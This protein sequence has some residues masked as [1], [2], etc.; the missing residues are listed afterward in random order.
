MINNYKK[1]YLLA[2]CFFTIGMFTN[3]AIAMENDQENPLNCLSYYDDEDSE[4]H[5]IRDDLSV[6]EMFLWME[7][8][9]I[10]GID[11]QLAPALYVIL[12]IES[13]PPRKKLITGL[14]DWQQRR[15]EEY[16]EMRL[17][18]RLRKFEKLPEWE[19]QARRH[20]VIQELIRD[21]DSALIQDLIEEGIQKRN[22]IEK[23]FQ[24]EA[25]T[26][27]KLYQFD[28]E[29]DNNWVKEEFDAYFDDQEKKQPLSLASRM[30]N[31]QSFFS[32]NGRNGRRKI[33]R[34]QI[35]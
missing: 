6:S 25:E 27:D 20:W 22:K 1:Q 8:Y 10:N 2:L 11:P 29:D 9:K 4:F 15:N 21:P 35:L 32:N 17:R 7:K 33:N 26:F 18:K 28:K 24:E 34:M 23:F 12:D 19:R 13:N 3:N 30:L 16:T 31:A 14:L 5:S